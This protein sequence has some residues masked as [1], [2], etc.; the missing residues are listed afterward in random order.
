MDAK[1]AA[2]SEE[3]KAENKYDTRG[4]EASYL[5]GAQAERTLVMQKEID[6]LGRLTIRTFNDTT[7]IDLTAIVEVVSDNQSKK[8][9]LILPN[10]GGTQIEFLGIKYF[11][12]TPKSPLGMKLMGKKVGDVIN[13]KTKDTDVEYEILSVF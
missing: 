9:F 7:A 2:T 10:S 4:L 12:I 11:V 3:S 13:F 1:N 8:F 6:L 5:A